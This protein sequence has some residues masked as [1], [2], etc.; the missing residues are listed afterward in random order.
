M[1]RARSVAAGF[2]ESCARW[3]AAVFGVAAIVMQLALGQAGAGA[4]PPAFSTSRAA[5]LAGRIFAVAGTSW[6]G[7]RDGK[8]LATA[9][10]FA[11]EAVAA[12]P[13]GGF[14]VA[15]ESR[16]WRVWPTGRTTLAAGNGRYRF[17]GDGGPAT[18]AWI[19]SV[20]G[21]AAL[22]DGGFLIAQSEVDKSRVRR[23]WP[24]GHISTVAGNGSD[25]VSGDGGPATAAGIGSVVGVAALPDG[26]FL[27]AAADLYSDSTFSVRQVWPNGHISTVAGNGSDLVSGDGG[28]ATAAGIGSVVGVAALPDGGFLIAETER[29]RRVWPDGHISTVAGNGDEGFSGNGGP[30]TAAMLSQV[31]GVAALPDGGF[32]IAESV[33]PN[34]N[35]RQI[36]DRYIRRVWPDGHISIMAGNGSGNARPAYFGDGGS[37]RTAPLRDYGGSGDSVAALPNGDV[38]VA[39]GSEVRLVLGSGGTDLLAAAIRPLASSA[40]TRGYRLRLVLTKRARVTV[41]LY[42]S[43]TTAAS[44]STRV[45]M[46]AG[47]STITVTSRRALKP[48]QY[49]VDV[50]ADT[51]SQHTR[52]VGWA[53]LGGSLTE[54][55][56]KALTSSVVIAYAV[57]QHQ[58]TAF[59]AEPA[60]TAERGQCHQVTASRVDCEWGSGGGCAWV[61]AS[62]LTSQGQIYS[63]NYG[64]PTLRSPGLFKRSP[65]WQAG[66]TWE[67]IGGWLS[68]P[69]GTRPTFTG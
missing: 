11:P 44:A 45:V 40:L 58:P 63:R 49:A 42:R 47:E 56:I 31:T 46:Q 28:P 16:V 43:A 14:L 39:F 33:S 13:G 50:R 6:A 53:Y 10:S 55:F 51:G 37:A 24:D 23:V 30:A 21:V 35:A 62:F 59:P 3:L 27:I 12:L 34:H 18:A 19:G 48:G 57:A 52:T 26:G 41:R 38:L 2:R 7:P 64:C 4:L 66:R 65:V 60:P 17:S 36:Q 22:G 15:D 61:S 20:M 5:S 8:G 68:V 32:V 25:L 67:D 1:L 69:S 29:V 9:R 54:S